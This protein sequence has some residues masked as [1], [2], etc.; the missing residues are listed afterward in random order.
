MST[1]DPASKPPGSAS[2]TSP[3]NPA[4]PQADLERWNKLFY[5]T[6]LGIVIA[7]PVIALLP[8]RKMDL[9]TF[10]LGIAWFMSAGYVVEHKTGKGLL[11]HIGAMIPSEGNRRRIAQ[12]QEREMMREGLRW[13][14]ET[15]R[16]MEQEQ[17][18]QQ[19]RG[20]WKRI[21]MGGERDDWV[22]ER[23][24]KE[25]EALEDGRG[26]AGLIADQVREAFGYKDTEDE[27]DKDK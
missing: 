25:K 11:W 9:Y 7:C 16:A 19:K 18:Q 20:F 5:N 24:R 17:Q 13:Q 4:N 2:P 8:P 14:G 12:E 3:G 23:M 15:P 27:D 26:Y 6:S 10:G 21:W 22:E 1:P